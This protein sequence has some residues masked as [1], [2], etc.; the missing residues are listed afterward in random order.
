MVCDYMAVKKHPRRLGFDAGRSKVVSQH[1]NQLSVLNTVHIM[2]L[3]S[4]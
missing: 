3:N 1:E 4:Q 2:G